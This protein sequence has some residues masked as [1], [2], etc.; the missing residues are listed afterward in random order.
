[1]LVHRSRAAG[2]RKESGQNLRRPAEVGE[3]LEQWRHRQCGP[4]DTLEQLHLQQVGH[5]VGHAD[6]V[7][8]QRR[9]AQG[10]GGARREGQR[11]E[12]MPGR[13]G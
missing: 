10:L 2:Q 1:M 13:P 3:R 11:V 7:D 8:P 9:R 6:D 4:G 12:D 5:T